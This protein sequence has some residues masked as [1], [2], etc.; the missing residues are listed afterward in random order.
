LVQDTYLKAYRFWHRFAPG[1]QARAW[2]FTI[3]RHT[4]ITVYRQRTR[5][6]MLAEGVPVEQGYTAPH[7]AP[8]EPEPGAVEA[9]LPSVVQDE[10]QQ[11]LAALPAVYRHVVLLADLEEYSYKDIAAAVGCPI[12]T[13]ESR[14]ARGR[15]LLRQRLEPFARAAGYIPGPRRAGVSPVGT[16]V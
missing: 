3:L 9:W 7:P 12:G 4:H 14:L 5:Q 13:V 10:V 11:A 16:R 1:T 2:L 15:K 8:A 6:P